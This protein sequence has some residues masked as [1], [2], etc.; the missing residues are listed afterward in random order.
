MLGKVFLASMLICALILSVGWPA[1]AADDD[2][3]PVDSLLS[4]GSNYYL[5]PAYGN[6]DGWDEEALYSTIQTAD[7]DG[8]GYREIF[9]RSSRGIGVWMYIPD[10]GT[11]LPVSTNLSGISDGLFESASSTFFV[12]KENAWDFPCYYET[13]QAADLDGDGDDEILARTDDGIVAYR[14]GDISYP[15]NG[16]DTGI[17]S[18]TWKKLSTGPAWSDS[19]WM[20][21]EYYSTIQ[22]ADIDGDGSAEVLGRGE[23]GLE[24]WKYFGDNDSWT[25]MGVLNDLSN[26]NGFDSEPYF[27]TLQFADVDGDGSEELVVRSGHG[28]YTYKYSQDESGWKQLSSCG[29]FSDAEGWFKD[30]YPSIT[31][32]DVDGDGKAELLGR[33][34]EGLYT[35]SWQYDSDREAWNWKQASLL[36]DLNDKNGFNSPQYYET[37]RFADV[38]GNPGEELMVRSSFGIS[39][40]N[41]NPDS[42]E[43]GQW[44][45][46]SWG[47]PGF[48]DDLGWDQPEYYSPLQFADLDG[49]GGSEM[50]IRQAHGML[51]YSYTSDDSEP[52]VRTET[53]YPDY[54][55]FDPQTQED[56]AYKAILDQLVNTYEINSGQD[57]REQYARLDKNFDDIKSDIDNTE[58]PAGVDETVMQTVKDQITL[59]IGV[60]ESVHYEFQENL[61]EIIRTVFNRNSEIIDAVTKSVEVDD[62]NKGQYWAGLLAKDFVNIFFSVVSIPEPEAKF[63]KIGAKLCWQLM[64]TATSEAL[65]KVKVSTGGSNTTVELEVAN[66]EEELEEW[67]K[68]NLEAIDDAYA[69]LAKSWSLMQAQIRMINARSIDWQSIQ[70]DLVDD[71]AGQYE[72][73]L[74][75]TLLPLKYDIYFAKN[76]YEKDGKDLFTFHQPPDSDI[77]T[78]YAGRDESGDAMWNHYYVACK[79]NSWYQFP[80]DDAMSR[81]WELGADPQNVFRRGPGWTGFER[82]NMAT[83]N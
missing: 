74:Y 37:I 76:T 10:F 71:L 70:D 13:I 17:V 42:A 44:I 31:T 51:T 4:V 72:L 67:F 3:T 49:S 15:E 19:G 43:T 79:I 1:P 82:I 50:L 68:A 7:F 5:S 35:F 52:W 20:P 23:Y 65:N 66:M 64:Q 32:A 39:T 58:T 11:Y 2:P 55:A 6:T 8:D 21:A 69:D 47:E 16:I 40:Y 30:Y 53:D 75:Q 26:I 38:D 81:I 14:A 25:S 73:S 29:P 33:G 78:E 28:I 83:G 27:S 60:V 34:E 59:E 9:A 41:Y 57:L 46:A 24:A 77:Y 48:S 18:W 61:R 63:A 36:E 56:C 80:S 62:V 12:A 45:R 54:D 22:T